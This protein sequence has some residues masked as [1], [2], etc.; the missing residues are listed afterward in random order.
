VDPE[1]LDGLLR[2]EDAQVIVHRASEVPVSGEASTPELLRVPALEVLERG[3][4][5]GEMAFLGLC[6]GAAL[7]ALET[8]VGDES[9]VGEDDVHWAELLIASMTLSANDAGLANY[10]IGLANWRRSHGF[11]SRCAQPNEFREG[12]HVS[13]CANGHRSHPRVEPVVQMLVHDDDRCLLG[14]APAWPPGWFSA[15][16][17]FV[18]PGETPEQAAVREV[19]EEAG[20]EVHSVRYSDAQ[21][22][23]GPYSLMLGC[24]ARAEGLGTAHPVGDELESVTTPTRAELRRAQADGS[25]KTPPAG[26]L[27]GSL[28]EGWLEGSL[29]A[30]NAR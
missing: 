19:R 6:D 7:F 23:A 17:G 28:I 5:P 8:S 9:L 13:V 3:A 26:V 30:Q 27:A 16:A 18:E 22:W 15:L 11:C 4:S 12:G 10:A 25:L 21:F 24:T 2:A 29:G 14:R 20:V 1:V